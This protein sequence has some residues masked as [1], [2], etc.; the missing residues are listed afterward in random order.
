MGA[1]AGGV[2]VQARTYPHLA[3][4]RAVDIF[5]ALKQKAQGTE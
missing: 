3:D 2:D 4:G 1:I 5:K